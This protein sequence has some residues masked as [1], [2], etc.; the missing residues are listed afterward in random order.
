MLSRQTS[1]KIEMLS[2]EK[3]YTND[4]T[5]DK[6]NSLEFLFDPDKLNDDYE[7]EDLKVCEEDF[8]LLVSKKDKMFDIEHFEFLINDYARRSNLKLVIDKVVG[9]YRTASYACREDLNPQ[10]LV[11]WLFIFL[12]FFVFTKNTN[13]LTQSLT[14]V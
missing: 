9:A 3:I 10:E 2:L 12:F 1:V 11:K 14:S 4:E 6:L 8:N 7:M 5:R 13:S